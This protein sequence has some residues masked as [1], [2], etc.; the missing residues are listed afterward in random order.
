MRLS[1][2]RSGA[3]VFIDANIPLSMILQEP[4]APL[5]RSFLRRVERR[6]IQG[7]TSVV[8]IGEIFHRALVA[9]VCRSLGVR[10][11]QAIRLLK[12]DPNLFDRLHESWVVTYDFLQLPLVTFVLDEHISVEALRLSRRY[13]LL[14][15]DATH[16][17]LMAH[18]GVDVMATFDR[19]L[20]RVDFIQV[21]GR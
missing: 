3:T 6:D 20:E 8:V 11:A 14:H 4:S 16:V 1:D 13:R 2:I 17:A 19:D 5:A 15:N 10:P 18:H 21:Y 12:S 7:V 9:E